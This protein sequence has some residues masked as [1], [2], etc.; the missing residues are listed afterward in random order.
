MPAPSNPDVAWA[1][2]DIQKLLPAR[3]KALKYYN[4]DHPLN[5]ATTKFVNTFGEMF[6]E[7]AD[8]LC[9]DVVNE[10]TDRL[11]LDS[12]TATAARGADGDTE[13]E[14]HDA[15][16]AEGSLLTS[17]AQEWWETNRMA[18]RS[19]TVHLNGFRAGDGF[20]I[21][22]DDGD[23]NPRPYIQDPRQMAV[24]YS[25]TKPDELEVAAKCWREGKGYRLNLYYPPTN[26]EGDGR[27]RIEHYY[28]KGWSNTSGEK[29]IP[30]ASAF[31]PWSAGQEG[32]ADHIPPVEYHDHGMPV[33]HF[34]NGEL[35]NYGTSVLSDIYPLQDA[36]NKVLCDFMVG[37]E[38]YA[39]PK[40]A[41][42]GVEVPRDP[43]TG[44]E[45]NPFKDGQNLWW[46]RN[47]KAVFTQ[48]PAA[49]MKG[50]HDSMRMLRL[51][52]ARKGAL[53]AH[54]VDIGST[55]NA[56][57]GLSLLIAEGKLIKRCKDRQRDWGVEW[58]RLVAYALSW[59]GRKVQ[60]EDLTIVWAPVETRD[61]KALLETLALKSGLGV[62]QVQLLREA[63]YTEPQ[64]IGFGLLSEEDR[65]RAMDRAEALAGGRVSEPGTMTPETPD[66]PGGAARPATA[67]SAA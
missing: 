10:P 8:N 16:Q 4:G 46:T 35:S 43:V 33:F 55:G 17:L 56:P 40:R 23:D 18:A 32:N 64:I 28:S 31:Q 1:I 5:F 67:G 66:G 53:P 20:V 37:G 12:W 34:P 57:S 49:E 15:A 21:V 52:I 41:A 13:P 11:Q 26:A 60:P 6:Q 7:L 36:L 62:P 45:D 50:F 42:T 2:A 25:K 51:E 24:R 39:L 22:W 19:G 30:Q 48:F 47:E 3:E 65:A 58:R 29:G 63:G 38:S 14:G 27:A 61:E 54:T 44:Q 9:D 59:G